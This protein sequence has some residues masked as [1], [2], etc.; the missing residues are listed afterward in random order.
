MSFN[1]VITGIVTGAAL[2][3]PV[4]FEATIKV[5]GKP[6]LGTTASA[7]ISALAFSGGGTLSPAASAGVYNY[8]YP[9]TTQTSITITVTAANHTI[10]LYVDGAY[11]QDLTSGAAS[12]A[13][14][15][16]SAANTS[17]L[18]AITTQE[19]GKT[20]KTYNIVAVRTA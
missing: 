17:K 8:S 14:L 18:I 12:A 15:G 13:I 7:G 9:F 11:V 19:S 2:E 4:S 20:P 1:G 6:S 3:D 10:K 5:S 16:F